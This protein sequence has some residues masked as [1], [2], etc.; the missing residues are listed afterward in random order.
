MILT[1]YLKDP[2]LSEM[3]KDLIVLAWYHSRTPSEAY[4]ALRDAVSR[5]GE[6]L[7][8]YLTEDRP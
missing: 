8:A 3:T 2:D 4:F 5:M 7:D 1:K 6:I